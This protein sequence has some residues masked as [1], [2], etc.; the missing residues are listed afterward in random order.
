MLF[1]GQLSVLFLILP[2]L[3]S[4]SKCTY[5]WH[6]YTSVHWATRGNRAQGPVLSLKDCCHDLPACPHMRWRDTYRSLKLRDLPQS[7]KDFL[8]RVIER[9]CLCLKTRT[10]CLVVLLPFPNLWVI[11]A[12]IPGRNGMLIKQTKTKNKKHKMDSLPKSFIFDEY[13]LLQL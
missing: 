12:A 4:F 9:A 8:K 5:R 11:T 13:T 3:F 10:F 7:R 1:L 2:F 6:L